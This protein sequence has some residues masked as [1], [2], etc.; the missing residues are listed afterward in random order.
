MT[1]SVIS[2]YTQA[3]ISSTKYCFTFTST[4]TLAQAVAT[5]TVSKCLDI[6]AFI[7]VGQVVGMLLWHANHELYY[8]HA[9]CCTTH[10]CM[11]LKC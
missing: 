11:A 9:S 4:C 10:M 7:K 2:L 5:G 3:N 1:I 6:K 8:F